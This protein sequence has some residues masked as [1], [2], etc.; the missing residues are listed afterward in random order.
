MTLYGLE[1]KYEVI[2]PLGEGGMGVVYLA[3]QKRI[4][5]K[6][7][8][9]SIAPYLAQDPSIR[10]RFTTEAAV[11]ARLN[12]PNIVTL[13]DYVEGE[14]ALYLVMEYVEGHS[15]SELLRQGPL[16]IELV[17][18]YF[19]QVLEAFS[20][21]HE[22]GVVHRDIKPANI[23]VTAEGRV[24]ILDFGVA[25]LF[26]TDHSLTRTGMRV[27]TLMYMSPEQI[28]GER[29]IDHRSDIYSLGV[30]LYEALVGR[31]PYPPDISEFDLSLKI[32]QE[33]IFDL[34]RP[35]AEIPTRL[36]EVI[37]RATE[38]Q[39]EYRYASCREFLRAFED[40]FRE[41]ATA[42]FSTRTRAVSEVE[43]PSKKDSKT[44]KS[45]WIGALIGLVAGVGALWWIILREP[46]PP[47]KLSEK[48]DTAEKVVTSLPPQKNT[49]SGGLSDKT[50]SASAISS[51]PPPQP[52][53]SPQKPISASPSPAR[54]PVREAS[55]S[56]PVRRALIQTEVQNFKEGSLIHPKAKGT[57]LIRN[58]GDADAS[59][60]VIAVRFL[61]K[62]GGVEY[63]DTLRFDRIEAGKSINHPIQAR[64]NGIK[65]LRVE[66][67][68]PHP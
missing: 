38:K 42:A 8:I 61:N 64:V 3:I 46:S 33:P 35:P 7:A 1:S 43:L 49:I 30:V 63:T 41:E 24:K 52:K 62:K 66:V 22:Q 37:L 47:S 50:S 31:P 2:R 65:S 14:N 21:A 25:R 19:S 5:R 68:F 29:N 67:L 51:G 45:V 55:P 53:S 60:V 44:R 4:D 26:Q 6:V 58:A 18:K 23:M 48:V 27:G 59:P 34:S 40:A 56:K 32:V 16:P 15:L 54:A 36:L 39:P 12:H 10:E 57:L 17:K 13:Y 11:L 9:K 20:Y 28:R